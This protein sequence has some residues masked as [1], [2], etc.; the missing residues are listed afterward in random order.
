MILIQASPV[1][2]FGVVETLSVVCEGF[3]DAPETTTVFSGILMNSLM[4]N[5]QL[6]RDQ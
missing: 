5:G 2:D 6:G 3:G 4:I 1:D